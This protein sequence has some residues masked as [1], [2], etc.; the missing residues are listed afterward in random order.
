MMYVDY[1]HKGHH[2]FQIF[3]QLTVILNDTNDNRPLFQQTPYD[4]E[5]AEVSQTYHFNPVKFFTFSQV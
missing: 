4:F 2:V 1:I 3:D 5:I